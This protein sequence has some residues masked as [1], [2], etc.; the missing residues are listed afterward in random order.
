MNLSSAVP[1]VPETIP[2]SKAP[3]NFFP[4]PALRRFSCL[5]LQDFFPAWNKASESDLKDQILIKGRN[6]GA[7][8]T[9]H[10]DTQAENK[11][12]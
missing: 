9:P 1:S 8:A 7:S 6:L 5:E 11:L 2:C 10:W 12:F 4:F 3:V